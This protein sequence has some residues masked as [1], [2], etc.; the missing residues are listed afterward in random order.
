MDELADQQSILQDSAIDDRE[1]S[2]GEPA[3]AERNAGAAFHDLIDENSRGGIEACIERDWGK[4]DVVGLR[5]ALS[6]WL[7]ILPEGSRWKFL[8][9][10]CGKVTQYFALSMNCLVIGIASMKSQT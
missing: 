4:G 1:D 7:P 5:K 9:P 10:A 6:G 3:G 8:R 2:G